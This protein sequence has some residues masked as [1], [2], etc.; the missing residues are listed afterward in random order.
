[1]LRG[2]ALHP[3]PLPS[4]DKLCLGGTMCCW[5]TGFH[6]KGPAHFPSCRLLVLRCGHTAAL[7]TLPALQGL[8]LHSFLGPLFF[9]TAWTRLQKPC[10]W[11]QSHIPGH[12]LAFSFS[13]GAMC[14]QLPFLPS[15][16][17]QH[18]KQAW[19]SL[20]AAGLP[21]SPRAISPPVSC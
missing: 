9:K 15:C 2:L 8:E 19:L 6:V 17:R 11:V 21:P 10:P 18:A 5:H 4:T 7:L 13:C 12:H 14:S 16:F 1:M 3:G 20:N